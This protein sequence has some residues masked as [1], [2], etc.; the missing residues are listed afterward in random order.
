[1][2]GADT[3]GEGRV[4]LAGEDGDLPTGGG[5][6]GDEEAAEKPSAAR[7]HDAGSCFV[8]MFCIHGDRGCGSVAAEAEEGEDLVA[9]FHGFLDAGCGHAAHFVEP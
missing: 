5:E 4:L 7:D 3:L 1:M 8:E 2:D 9:E 6:G